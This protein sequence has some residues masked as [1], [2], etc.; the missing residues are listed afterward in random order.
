M[1]CNFPIKSTASRAL[2]VVA[3]EA[4]TVREGTIFINTLLF[5]NKKLSFPNLKHKVLH[6][7]NSSL[8]MKIKKGIYRFIS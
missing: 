8:L 5:V 7:F 1:T 4:S 3:S 2:W 6:V